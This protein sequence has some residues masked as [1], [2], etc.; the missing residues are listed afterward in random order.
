MSDVLLLRHG[1][2]EWNATRRLQGRHDSP[3]TALGRN[4][5]LALSRFASSFPLRRVISSPAGRAQTTAAAI[6]RAC[7]CSVVTHPALWEVCFGRC[8]GLYEDE[9]ER[10]FPG[11]T[12]RRR[13]DKWHT[14]WPEGE[15]YASAAARVLPWVHDELLDPTSGPVAVVAHQGLNRVLLHLLAGI[16]VADVLGFRNPPRSS[17]AGTTIGSSTYACPMTS[18]AR[19]PMTSVVSALPTAWAGARD[20]PASPWARTFAGGARATTPSDQS[21]ACARRLGRRRS[22]KR[23]RRAVAPSMCRVA[24]PAGWRLPPL[25]SVR[26]MVPGRRATPARSMR[27]ASPVGPS[28]KAISVW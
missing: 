1:Q 27:P 6:A 19:T 26:R 20:Y 8:G 14:A 13:R 4:Q 18:C 25:Q 22:P 9:V 16:P 23:G 21:D 3:L 2:T 24:G 5:V 28:A 11:F 17:C 12:E 10:R 15:S 7:G